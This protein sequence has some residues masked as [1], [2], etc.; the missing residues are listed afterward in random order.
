M[1]NSYLNIVT[2]LL[3]TLFYYL[4][5]KPALPYKL[6]NNKEEYKKYVSNNYMYLAIYILLVIV[7]K[8]MVNS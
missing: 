8:F 3:T 1:A 7:I 2:F 4:A 6:Y 5:L